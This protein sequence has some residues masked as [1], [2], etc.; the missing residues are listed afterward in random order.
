ML[1]AKRSGVSNA[2]FATSVV[3]LMIVAAVGFALY[4]TTPGSGAATEYTTLTKSGPR[5]LI[6]PTET[7]G[8]YNGSVVTFV[9]PYQ[10]KCLPSLTS[11]FSN[12]TSA[13]ALTQCEVGAGSATAEQGAAALWVIVPA[14]AGLSIFGVGKL[15]ASPQ[16]FPVYNNQT[17]VTQCG[18]SGTA[19]GCPDHPFLLYSPFF[20]AV[21][22]HLGL[23]NGY[24]NLPEGV[25][26][27]PAHD[28]L[29]DCCF[30]TVPW[31]TIVVLVFDPNIFPNAVTGQC[32]TSAPSNLTDSSGNCLSNY[33]G[34][35][36]AL[37]THD[38]GVA[39]VNANNPV[40]QTLGDPTEQVVVP[41]AA[42]VAQIANANSNLFEHF[43]V[44]ATD[45][46]LPCSSGNLTAC[47]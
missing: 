2:I 42:T 28:H 33:N 22:E 19:S 15:G 24:G 35:L 5:T 14:F 18:A 16:G 13:A 21:E 36:R 11:Y 37:T 47:K 45:Y 23:R 10:Y 32:T 9:Y 41:G 40:W 6:R 8:F 46:Y 26:P 29:I 12:E 7:A 39:T 17:V 38:S 20:T 3:V 1:P 4:A 43:T 30:Q 34:L 25:L 31:Y 27:T 44:N